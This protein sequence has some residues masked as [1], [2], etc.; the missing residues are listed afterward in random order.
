MPRVLIVDDDKAQLL[1]IQDALSGENLEIV[2]AK[3]AR[4]T[5]E[6]IYRQIPDLIILDIGL[7]GQDGFDILRSIRVEPR[8]DAVPIVIYS[9]RH[10]I[11]TKTQ[12]LDL[13]AVEYLEKPLR[14]KELAAHARAILRFKLKQDQ[15]FE[16]Y[17]RLSELSLTD[18]LTGA[19]N[20]RALDT[21]LK[22][23]LSE[24]SRHGIPVSCAMFDIDH[25]KNVNDS[26]GH[27]VGDIVLKDISELVRGLCRQEDALIRYGGE[28]Y[29][30]I[31]FHTPRD[32]AEIFGE[33]V[34][35]RV[36]EHNFRSGDL[37][38]DITISGGIASQPE[39][40]LPAD[41]EAMIKLA[42]QRLY[43]AKRNGRDQ[44]I[45]TG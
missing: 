2:A 28:E 21:F 36:A 15:I 9:G 44:V 19:Y 43:T 22:S 6:A 3:D 10:D 17:K 18:P 42:D 23:R 7:P 8:Y 16:E 37:E 12:A 34:R 39:D 13:G 45:S 33:R 24:S 29:L 32:G 20:R 11:D 27:H 26:H 14:P 41:P 30:V 1:L 31:L 38:I 40:D 35:E 5:F 4:E 25:F